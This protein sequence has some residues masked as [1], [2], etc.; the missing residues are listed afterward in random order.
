MTKTI[1]QIRQQIA[2]LQAQEHALLQ[3]EALGV[4]AKIK[5]AVNHYGITAEQ[6]FGTSAPAKKIASRKA[7]PHKAT[8]K[9]SRAKPARNTRVAKA[10]KPA[11]EVGASKGVKVAA[12]YKDDA[13]NAWSGRGSRP[14]WLR[15]ALDAGKQLE[16]FAVA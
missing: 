3:K 13:G 14:R 8:A 11:A 1:D 7:K 10:A 2:K 4:I 16:D 5:E 9:T 6:I 15:A 12:K